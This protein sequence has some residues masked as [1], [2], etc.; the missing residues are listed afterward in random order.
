MGLRRQIETASFSGV[1]SVLDEYLH[2]VLTLSFQNPEEIRWHLQYGIIHLVEAMKNLT[3]LGEKETRV[4]YESLALSLDGTGTTQ[5]MVLAF[6]EAMEKFLKLTHGKGSLAENY[7][8]EKIKDYV[9][10][11]FEEHLRISR[12]AGMAKISIST[13]S[14]RF[15]KSTGMGLEIYLQNLR[16]EK[17]RRL[18]K[19][20]GL[21]VS[22]IAK[23]CG[24]GSSS[25]FIRLFRRKTGISPQKFR[26]N[27]KKV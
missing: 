11:H 14:R 26:Q 8:I 22:Q 4:F 16:L 19:T 3:D 7:S 21:P 17:A 24:F 12:L 10:R 6:K 1:E 13:L 27:P 15:K 25:Y 5:E 18:L 2:E 23:A 9:D 20:G